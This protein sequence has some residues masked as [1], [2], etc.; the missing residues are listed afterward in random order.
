MYIRGN[1]PVLGDNPAG[2]QGVAAGI[3]SG[4]DI[5]W[6]FPASAN[7]FT[8]NHY[9]PQ[10]SANFTLL[11][12]EFRNELNALGS[13]YTLTAALPSGPSD[14]NKIDVAGAAQYLDLGDVMSYDMHGAW[15]TTGP[16]DFQSPTY[17][18][19]SSPAAGTGF[20]A[21]DAIN[22][23]LMNGFPNNKL[24][25][26][27]P[28]Y[29]RGWTGVP[30][31]GAHG[32]YQTATGPSPAYGYSQQPGV[33]MYKELEAD[34]KLNTIYYDPFS[35]S[36]WVYDGTNF[37]SIETPASLAFK[38]QYIKDKGL[39]GIMMYSLEADDSSS[40]LLHA[41]TGL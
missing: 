24:V 14:I 38:R 8:G 2:G 30:D 36:T 33:A 22:R 17:D 3:F 39:G 6:E 35:Q 11:L 37:W 34:G 18:A 41:A 29:G 27:V 20:T 19:P 31:G 9:G 32:L 23:Y 28:F 7:G 25:M 4:F 21:N 26:G 1:L 16:A 12:A 10:D 13:G 40:T 5:D 15:E